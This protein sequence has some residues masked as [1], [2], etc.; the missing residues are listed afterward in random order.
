MNFEEIYRD[1]GTVNPS[2]L[3]AFERMA[4]LLLPS[5]YRELIQ[6]HDAVRLVRD[7]F[8]FTN[9]FHDAGWSY[10]LGAD[11]KD[12][13]DI[14]FY[15]FGAELPEYARIDYNQNF[16]VYGHDHIVAFGTAAN[17]D[18]ICFDYR[19]DPTSSEPHVVVMFHDAYDETNKMLISNVADSFEQFLGMLY[20]SE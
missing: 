18:Y 13:R 8:R 4:Q 2:L 14:S 20:K 1:H 7:S 12:S 3:D 10:R 9:T 15:G 17:G 19:H 11:G 5:K 16:D 6:E